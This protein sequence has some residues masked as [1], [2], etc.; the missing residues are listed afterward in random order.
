MPMSMMLDNP[1]YTQAQQLQLPIQS[2][3]EF[4]YDYSKTKKR[5]VIGGSHGKTTTTSMIMHVLKAQ[6]IKFDWLVGSQVNGFDAMVG[7]SDD[8][9]TIVIEGDEYPDNKINLKAKFLQYHHDIGILNGIERDHVNIYQ[10]FE[11]YL[12]VFR[13][14]VQQTPPDGMLYYNATDTNVV[15]AIKGLPEIPKQAYFPHPYIMDGEICVALDQI[16]AEYPLQIF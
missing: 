8:A 10:T 6:G 9:K 11:S 14:F 1:E 5:I 13:D 15:Q 12:A 4:I 3:P 16:D 7:L 2:F